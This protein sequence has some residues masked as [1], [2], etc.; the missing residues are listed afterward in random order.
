MAMAL[1]PNLK[2]FSSPWSAPGWMKTSGKMS[3]D[4]ILK[5]DIGGPYYQIW[6]NYFVR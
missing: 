6:A 1:T 3:G 5:G 2:L 4:G